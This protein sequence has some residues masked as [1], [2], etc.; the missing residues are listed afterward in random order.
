M[1]SI[2]PMIVRDGLVF[3]IDPGNNQSFPGRDLPVKNG[4][5]LWLDAGDPNTIS[6]SA[7]IL[8]QWRDKSNFN[9]S[10]VLNGNPKVISN[11]Q[12]S[13]TAISCST[14]AG[15]YC[16]TYFSAPVTIIYA[17]KQTGGANERVLQSHT[18][19][20]WLLGYW[21]GNVN[22]AY[23]EGW[24]VG[25]GGIGSDTTARIHSCTI[26]G[27]GLNS[28]FY[29]SGNQLGS[30]GNGTTAPHGIGIN[31]G[32]AIPGEASNCAIFEILIFNRILSNNELYKVHTYLNYKWGINCID[33]SIN[34]I[35][36]NGYTS[37]S[38]VSGSIKLPSYSPANGGILNFN[39]L[40]N[41]IVINNISNL[42][43]SFNT[44]ITV[45]FWWRPNLTTNFMPMGF[46]V[47]D[48]FYNAGDFGFNT[49]NGDIWG[50]G[51]V[52]REGAWH[53]I[54]AIFNY[55]NTTGSLLY[56]NS[57]PI[58]MTQRSSTPVN[59]NATFNGGNI[60]ISGW[61]TNLDYVFTGS[62]SEFRIYNRGLSRLEI[63]QN[64]AASRARYG[65]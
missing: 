63:V 46:G 62:M 39:G 49:G 29:S 27:F 9:Q 28:S 55:Q 15:L 16:A 7:S 32:G 21:G 58:N 35:S 4:L 50:S 8:L 18:I 24:V 57:I 48:L 60:K 45:D 64:F 10:V 38:L 42:P 56:V 33:S 5:T 37:G 25:P 43:S 19:D 61:K 52:L 34:D 26:G 41:A 12:N 14:T 2:S 3:S 1:T 59:S 47:N 53:Y 23:F 40:N 51:S 54:S 20:N 17:S 13:L 6:V 30:N 22:N 65:V 31:G 44:T 11:A 36:N